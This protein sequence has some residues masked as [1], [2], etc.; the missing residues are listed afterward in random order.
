MGS[1]AEQYYDLVW[2]SVRNGPREVEEVLG[3]SRA[4]EA[5]YERASRGEASVAKRFFVV[6]CYVARRLL[7]EMLGSLE[8][9]PGACAWLEPLAREMIELAGALKRDL[10]D[11]LLEYRVT[12][13][14]HPV[15][16][17]LIEALAATARGVVAYCGSPEK[18]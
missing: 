15:T 3:A 18:V 7:E 5:K 11:E 9:L 2:R 13:G 6:A 14:L 17:G 8:D 12:G 1:L 16:L 4:F 10:R